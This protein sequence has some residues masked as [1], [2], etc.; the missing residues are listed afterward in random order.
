MG[1]SQDWFS[2]HIATWT[3]LLIELKGKPGVH[4]LEIGSFEGR[5]TCWLL[6]NIL[7]GDGSRIDCIDT[8]MGGE[9]HA[10]RG[11][12]WNTLR[13]TFESNTAPWR[14]RVSVHAGESAGIL[15]RLP[16]G[17]DLVYIDGSHTAPHV[18][19]DAV[20][21]W[22]L[23]KTDGIMIFDD[24]L[25]RQDP[26]PEHCPRLAID[27]FLRCH[28]GWFDVL[29]AEY[30]IAVRKRAAYVEPQRTGPGPD[31][32]QHGSSRDTKMVYTGTTFT[33]HR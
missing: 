9:E 3:G 14:D 20:L 26:R 5:S 10:G 18:L 19:A 23:L 11:I 32:W 15:R 22:P 29:H 7:T 28:S 4:A 2:Q 30:Q 17:Y 13:R 24:Y 12:D 16:A 31:S 8:F 33:F 1:F 27:S 6:E 21:S 25:W